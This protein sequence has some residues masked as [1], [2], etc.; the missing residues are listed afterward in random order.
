VSDVMISLRSVTK[1]FDGSEAAAVADLSL[2]VNRGET[3]VLVGPS[4]CGKTTTMK[5]INRLIEPSS[6]TI[7]VDGTDILNQDPVRLRRG[8]GY[9]IQSIGLLPHKTISDNVATVPKLMGW[10]DGRISKRIDELVSIFELD[11]AFLDRY[12]AE[13]SGGQRQRVGVA[14]ALAV[15]PPVML[16]DEPFGAVDPIV[17]ERLQDQFRDIQNRLKKT[18]VFVTHDIDEAI[19][20][21]DRIAIL[22]RGGVVE[23]YASPEEILRAPANDFVKKFVGTER[24]LKRLA[25]MKVSEIEVEEGPVVAPSAS[26]DVARKTM[27]AFGVDWA[28]VIDDGELLGWIDE[29]SLEGAGTVG[30]A[31]RRPFSAYVTGESTLRQ[32]LDSIV[33]SRTNVAVVATEGQRYKGILSLERISREIVA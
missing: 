26:T 32:A 1:S 8:I 9:V 13:L 23:Q 29:Q 7:E 10:D 27:E 30:A 28:S 12:P 31:P 3:V 5:M 18:I 19:K 21:A 15:D 14:R 2:D 20:M 22:N 4:G 16:M 33:T 25:L 24:G 11:P 17:R 6:G